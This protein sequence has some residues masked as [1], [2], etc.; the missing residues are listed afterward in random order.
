MM[1]IGKNP[2]YRENV[3]VNVEYFE[4][5]TSLQFQSILNLFKAIKDNKC[6]C[7]QFENTLKQLNDNFKDLK[8][9]SHFKYSS[10]YPCYKQA[11]E[12]V[13]TLFSSLQENKI[14]EVE[15]EWREIMRLP[16]RFYQYEE[17]ITYGQKQTI[18]KSNEIFCSMKSEIKPLVRNFTS[19]LGN[20]SPLEMNLIAFKILNEKIVIQD[21]N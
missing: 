12:T 18:V 2:S 15:I 16:F 10:F 21:Q 1:T 17:S 5:K 6:S 13:N 3:G 20:D 4:E 9:I 8:A 11:V 7:K 19:S 14:V